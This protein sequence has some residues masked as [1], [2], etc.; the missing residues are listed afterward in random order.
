M[1][2]GSLYR[3]KGL[4]LKQCV[5]STVVLLCLVP[6]VYKTMPG[7]G[8]SCSCAGLASAQ[9]CEHLEISKINMNVPIL[10]CTIPVLN[11]SVSCHHCQFLAV[12]IDLILNYFMHN[13]S[14]E[15]PS[16]NSCLKERHLPSLSNK[17][18]CILNTTAGMLLLRHTDYYYF[19]LWKT[20]Y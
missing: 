18:C 12:T 3:L 14:F 16:Q 7:Q 4:F 11:F 15:N 19:K 6:L 2:S 8:R 13:W 10:H 20:F 1:F 17:W 5:I 9:L